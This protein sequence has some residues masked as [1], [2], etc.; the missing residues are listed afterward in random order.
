[1]TFLFSGCGAATVTPP[2]AGTPV[3]TGRGPG[4]IDPAAFKDRG[5]LAF[6][7]NGLLYNL[8]EARGKCS[9]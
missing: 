6:V 2:R 9:G 8:G 4:V 1:M 3:P 7:W 5:D